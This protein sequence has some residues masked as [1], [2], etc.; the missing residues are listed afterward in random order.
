VT[1]PQQSQGDKNNRPDQG[2]KGDGNGENNDN[3][4]G[5]G[6]RK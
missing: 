6:K 3:K 2:H 1:A 4:D 5:N